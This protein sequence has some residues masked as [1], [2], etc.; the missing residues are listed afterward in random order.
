MNLATFLRERSRGNPQTLASYTKEIQRF[1]GWLG[2]RGLTLEAVH[3]YA[4]YLAARYAQNSIIPKATAVNLFLMWKGTDYR[5]RRPPKRRDPNPR[6]V[7]VGEYEDLVARISDAEERLVVRLLHDSFLRPS[8][9]VSIRLAEIA[10]EEGVTIVRKETQKTGEPSESVLSAETAAELRSHVHVR[11]ITD[12]LF[13]ASPRARKAVHRERT[14]P[15]KVL[16][17][18]D[19]G[20]EPRAFRRTGATSWGPDL[21]SLMAQGGW[22]DPKTILFHY[23]QDV[24]SRHVREAEKVIGRVREQKLPEPGPM[25]RTRDGRGTPPASP[26]NKIPRSP[27]VA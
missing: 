7:K 21:K 13:P 19:A 11:G 24:L 15:N 10:E 12:Y 22:R 5:M 26:R 25:E 18:H 27:E 20:F 3:G 6:L 1:R 4:D 23:R 8:D 16:M 17:R 14:W 9:V 2:T